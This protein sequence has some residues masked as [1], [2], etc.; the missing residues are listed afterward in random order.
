MIELIKESEVR[1]LQEAILFLHTPLCGTCKMAG[2]FLQIV[3][4]IPDVPEILALDLNLAPNMA[5]EWKIESVPCLLIIK[6]SN[7]TD[8][9]YAFKSVTD[10]ASF[11]TSNQMKGE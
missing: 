7:V 6:D 10:V 3:E 9:M 11:V 2:Q 5:K 1:G 8:K 4:Q